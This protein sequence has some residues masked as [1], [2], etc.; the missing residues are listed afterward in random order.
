MSSVTCGGLFVPLVR[1][2]LSRVTNDTI[3]TLVMEAEIKDASTDLGAWGFKVGDSIARSA[4]EG[5]GSLG[6]R[7]SQG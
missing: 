1:V 7:S 3:S 6:V 4:K 5:E 2:R